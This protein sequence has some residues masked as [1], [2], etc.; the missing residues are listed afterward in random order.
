MTR[1]SL[2]ALLATTDTGISPLLAAA[3]ALGIVG[4]GL[5][6]TGALALL[7]LHPIRF[8]VRTLLGL[9]F[10][11]LGGLAALLCAGVQGYR[12]LTH[13]ELAA[14]VFVRPTGPQ[15]FTA[16]VRVTGGRESTFAIAGD[17]I[18]VDAHI[19]KWKPMANMLGLHTAFELDRVSGRFRNVQQE[20]TAARTV[21]P[22]GDERTVDLF[23]LRK[24]HEWLSP[25]LDAE[26]GSATFVSV[27]R[28][29]ELEVRV[30][31]SGLLMREV[32]STP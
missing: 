7:G 27:T 21:Y 13:E 20:R 12:T 8:T 24:Q 11:A 29:A 16:T 2:L 5:I 30:S 15:H 26:Y 23:D 1:Q 17:E 3:I 19:L 10:L 4:T 25:L 14:R 18:S 22:L 6:V 9:A 28:P 31:T 32:R